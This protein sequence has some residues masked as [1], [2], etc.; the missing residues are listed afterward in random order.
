MFDLF[1]AMMVANIVAAGTGPA[2]VLMDP[3]TAW[4]NFGSKNS[5][6]KKFVPKKFCVQKYL[7]QYVFGPK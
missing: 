6:S 5:G 2:V 1:G 7:A 4:K 3:T